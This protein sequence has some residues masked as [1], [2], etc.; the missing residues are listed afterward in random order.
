MASD[1]EDITFENIEYNP[2]TIISEEDINNFYDKYDTSNNI[3]QNIL[4]KYEKTKVISERM[5]MISNGS[6]VF[7]DNPEKYNNIYDIV[8]QELNLK[9]I[10]FIIK[11]NLGNKYEYWKLEDLNII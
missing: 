6:S 10:P 5:N 11:R 9:K 3:S 8:I 1:D 4:T 7:I 2:D